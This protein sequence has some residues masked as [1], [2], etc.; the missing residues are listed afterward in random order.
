MPT[1]FHPL[2][3]CS[4]SGFVLDEREQER[5]CSKLH[6]LLT[7]IRA[8]GQKKVIVW[9]SP[10]S[11]LCWSHVNNNGDK[12]ETTSFSLHFGLHPYKTDL[13]H[14][15]IQSLSERFTTGNALKK[16]PTLHKETLTSWKYLLT[17]W[18]HHRHCCICL[19]SNQAALQT[20]C[21]LEPSLIK[22]NQAYLNV[23]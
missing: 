13:H 10:P 21:P 8:R 12:L 23:C 6:G 11:E 14:H 2:L 15:Q 17:F 7:V 16:N 4:W 20:L 22:S 18:N 5:V 3:V 9:P 1:S 19:H